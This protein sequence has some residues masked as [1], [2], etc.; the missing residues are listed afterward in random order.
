MTAV[1][2]KIY[3]ARRGASFTDTDA[4]II[5]PAIEALAAQ[6]NGVSPDVIVEAAR[7]TNSSLHRYFAA[8]QYQASA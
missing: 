8:S 1:Q 4:A 2:Q 6:H 5:G 3:H 7:R